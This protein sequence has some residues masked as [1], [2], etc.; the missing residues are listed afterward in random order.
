MNAHRRSVLCRWTRHLARKGWSVGDIASLHQVSK[1]DV[2]SMLA[3]VVKQPPNPR[4]P[5]AC[6]KKLNAWSEAAAADPRY[7]DRLE[8]L[9]APAAAI[10]R[11]EPVD[12][13]AAAELA[14]GPA[15]PP[16]AIAESWG[17]V[18]A[19][20]PRKITPAVLAAAIKS[21][22]DGRSWPAIARELGC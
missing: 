11:P 18:H 9:E 5:G 16:P 4:Y 1:A 6:F 10:E 17:S 7:R 20:G 19:S 15:D 13:P 2:L 3:P 22:Q 8:L 14:P 12:P 21:H